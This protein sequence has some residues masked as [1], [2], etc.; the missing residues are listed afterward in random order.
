MRSVPSK[1]KFAS[2]FNASV[3]PVAESNLLSAWFATDTSDIPVNPD[4]LPT[5][6]VAVITPAFPNFI[7]LPTSN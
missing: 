3:V 4:P 7:L 5:K 6:L 1:V 2:A